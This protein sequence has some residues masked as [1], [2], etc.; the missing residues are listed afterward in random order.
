MPVA[1]PHDEDLAPGTWRLVRFDGV[2]T[3]K[4]A[5]PRCGARGN[6]DTHEIDAAGVVN[7]SVI[8][9]TDGCGWHETVQL[10]GWVGDLRPA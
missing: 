2:Y 9:P 3:A 1:I 8:C 5:C 6:L 7:P 10:V 4:L